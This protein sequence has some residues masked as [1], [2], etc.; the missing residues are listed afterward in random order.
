MDFKKTLLGVQIY[1]HLVFLAGLFYVPWPLSIATIIMSQ[2]IYVGLCGTV[3][4]H[5]VVAHKNPII[6]WIENGLLFLSWIGASGSAIAW[7]GTHRKHHRYVDTEKDPHCPKYVGVLRAY[8]YSSGG[9]DIVRYAP[10]LLRK[11]LYLF[12]HKYYFLFL[13]IA[14]GLGLLV[15]SF[16][17]YWA[18]LV[19][20]AF[21][22]WFA[23]S[24]VNVFCHDKNGPINIPLLGVIHAGEGW[25]SNHHQNPTNGSFQ[26][27]S[28]WG[29]YLFKL[30]R[31]RESFR[32]P[33]K[34]L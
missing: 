23:G 30:I 26:H 8:W 32:E 22:M 5:R 31:R 11:P 28:D 24:T 15:L 12:Q 6:P 20:P 4:Y 17:M 16:Q 2:I 21:L 29:Q 19:V 1:V 14:H 3:Y 9:D 25:H 33:A 18:F 7:A 27:W 13:L 10:D 34:V